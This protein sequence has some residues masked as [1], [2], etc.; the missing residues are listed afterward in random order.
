MLDPRFKLTA[1]EVLYAASALRAEARRPERHAADPQFEPCR[2]LLA[3]TAEA[4]DALAVRVDRMARA[5]GA[6]ASA[7][8]PPVGEDRSR[9]RR[10][11]TLVR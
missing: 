4:Y 3:G 9:V 6:P 11:S 10:R 2:A 7:A 5:V 8:D 1:Q